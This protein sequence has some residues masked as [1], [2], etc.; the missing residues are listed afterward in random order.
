MSMIMGEFLDVAAHDMM[1]LLAEY[2]NYGSISSMVRSLILFRKVLR[3]QF[4][5][6]LQR[7]PSSPLYFIHVLPLILYW[8]FRSFNT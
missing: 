7:R 4:N 3:T 8:S 1:G 6:L 2:K 5:R